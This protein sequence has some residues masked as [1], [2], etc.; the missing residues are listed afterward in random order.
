MNGLICDDDFISREYRRFVEVGCVV[1]VTLLPNFAFSPHPA[2]TPSTPA[3]LD[4]TQIRNHLEA[5]ASRGS[6]SGSR[7][8]V[9]PAWSL[10]SSDDGAGSS[11]AGSLEEDDDFE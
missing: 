10:Y 2:Q 11:E 7:L 4:S 9:D 8:E 5:E 6:K 1:V 3:R